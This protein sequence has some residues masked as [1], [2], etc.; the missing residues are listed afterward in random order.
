MGF[1]FL[2][3]IN[4][5]FWVTFFSFLRVAYITPLLS[6]TKHTKISFK[7]KKKISPP[8][9]NRTLGYVWIGRFLKGVNTVSE[10]VPV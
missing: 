8:C 4:F 10:A 2:V 1:L 5:F 3:C 7:K 9:K 6:F